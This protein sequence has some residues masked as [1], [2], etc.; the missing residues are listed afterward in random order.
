VKSSSLN[1]VT[2]LQRKEEAMST[3]IVSSLLATAFAAVPPWFG[4]EPYVFSFDEVAP[5][6]QIQVAPQAPTLAT[7]LGSEPFLGGPDNA[8]STAGVSV[9]VPQAERPTLATSLGSEPSILGDLG[10]FAAAT[11]RQNAGAGGKVARNGA[12]K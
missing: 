9:M 11:P 4:S 3:L 8:P 7:S 10:G 2:T 6:V 12:G 5:T 1:D